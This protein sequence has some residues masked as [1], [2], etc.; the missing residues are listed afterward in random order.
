MI[1]FQY[2][3]CILIL[4]SCDLGSIRKQIRVAALQCKTQVRNYSSDT[5][6]ILTSQ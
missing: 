3:T 4:N 2:L 1:K 6:L 5:E